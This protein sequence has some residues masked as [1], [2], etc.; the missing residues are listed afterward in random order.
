MTFGISL[1]LSRTNPR[2]E[3]VPPTAAPANTTA[4]QIT[5]PLQSTGTVTATFGV[6]T[7]SPTSYVFAWL[8]NGTPIAGATSRTLRLTDAEVGKTL[9][10]SVT[11]ANSLGSATAVSAGVGPIQVK[12]ETGPPQ[13][14]TAPTL[15]GTPTEGSTLMST[16]GTWTKNPTTYGFQWYRNGSIISGATANIIGLIAADVGAN[17]SCAVTATNNVGSTTAT[18]APVGP[19]AAAPP[20]ISVKIVAEGDSLT[21]GLGATDRATTSYPGR[22]TTYLPTNNSYSVVNLGS[23]GIT[24]DQIDTSYASRG[25]AEFDATKDL[26]V[27]VLTA[28]TNDKFNNRTDRQAYHSLRS[29]LSKAKATGYQRR[30]IGTILSTDA[31]D[32]PNSEWN[33]NE[34]QLNTWI[35]RYWA[36]D[37]EAHALANFGDNAIFDTAAAT[38]ATTY[39]QDDRIHLKDAGYDLMA[40]IASPAIVST[41]GTPTT[42]QAEDRWF[43]PDMSFYLQATENGRLLSWNQ[44]GF[45]ASNARGMPGKSTGKWYFETEIVN[46]FTVQVGLM[47]LEFAP[48]ILADWTGADYSP[49][50]IGLN[51]EDAKIRYDNTDLIDM[52]AATNGTIISHA[53]DLDAKRYWIRVGSG[54]WNNSPTANPAT[55]TGGIDISALGTGMIYP[56]ATIGAEG[57]QVRSRF[58][59][60]NQTQARPT[61]FSAIA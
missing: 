16:T 53:V 56:V 51:V 58:K 27:F 59:Q 17:I 52:N 30:V 25:G 24:A 31:G 37:L 61:G 54:T 49:Y 5:G 4:P 1:S 15:S 35:E 3:P 20:S 23:S 32:P 34:L 44:P 8:A 12:P 21:D 28:G 22:L 9:T 47:N 39:W 18:T 36:Y 55:N 43:E 45:S 41:F 46:T 48:Y 11:A 29:I 2:P 7:Q 10:V 60:V 13:L 38:A 57:G 6:W 19:I 42:P 40:Q 26:N 14:V 33:A 50:A